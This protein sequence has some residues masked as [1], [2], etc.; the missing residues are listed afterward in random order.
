MSV[1]ASAI[2]R[3]LTVGDIAAAFQLSADAGWNQTVEDWRM[4]IDLSPEGCIAIDVDGEISATA[5]LMCYGRTLAW[6][7]M[8]LTKRQHRGQGFAR[9]LL[10]QALGRA[11]QMGI[12]TVELDATDEGKPIYE[13]LGFRSEHAAERWSRPASLDG[14][15]NLSNMPADAQPTGGWCSRDTNAFG[16]DRSQVLND[17]SRRN[18]PLAIESSYVLTRP[19]R[20]TAH[21]GPCVS[22]S[23][24]TA[25]TLIERA[26]QTSSSSWSWDLLPDNANAVAIARDFGF[27]PRRRLMRMV[28]GKDLRTKTEEIY[29]IAGFEL[30]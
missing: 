8:V 20:Q 16:A 17:L 18:P 28:R 27:A 29:A 22:D 3:P 2:L 30:G 1:S 11:D 13:E 26:L 4:L 12:E 24:T 19:G 15:K 21:L 23:P 14:P 6:V 5:T 10:T 7:G 9:R 25:R